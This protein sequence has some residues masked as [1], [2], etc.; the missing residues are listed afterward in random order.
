M[1]DSHLFSAFVLALGDPAG[2]ASQFPYCVWQNADCNGDGQV[3]FDD[4]NPFVELL[5]GK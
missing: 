4:I 5:S 3:T 2:Y 1:R